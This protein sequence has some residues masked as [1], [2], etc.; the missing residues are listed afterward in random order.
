MGNLLI[1]F[2]VAT[3]WYF[4]GDQ[5]LARLQAAWHD[6]GGSPGLGG[7]RGAG[8]PPMVPAAVPLAPGGAAAAASALPLAA[9]PGLAAPSAGVPGDDEFPRGLALEEVSLHLRPL[10][11]TLLHLK[12]VYLQSKLLRV[13][14]GVPGSQFCGTLRPR[15]IP[16]GVL[17]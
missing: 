5:V 15:A 8:V 13:I 6:G 9:T 7:A 10:R 4:A 3:F 12:V 11:L 14:V 16:N 2:L 17:I 1:L